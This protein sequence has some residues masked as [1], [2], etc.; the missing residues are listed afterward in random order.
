MKYDPSKRH[1]RSI[2]LK[3]YDYTQPGVYFI[4]LVTH[5]RQCLFG[6]IAAGGGIMLNAIGEIAYEEW[7]KSAEIRREMKLDE[8]IIM[9]NHV[10]GIVMILGDDAGPGGAHGRAPLLRPPKSLGAFVAG[11]K[12]VVTKRINILRAM[13]GVPVW[14]RNYYEHIVRGEADLARIRTHTRNN[15]ARWAL[16]QLYPTALPNLFNQDQL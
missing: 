3:G 10:H 1:R 5:N 6:D 8:F 11:F 4:T 7:K 15:P 9:P 14:Q 2:R 16:D 13:P 12:S